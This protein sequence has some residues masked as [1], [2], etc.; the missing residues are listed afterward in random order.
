MVI[1]HNIASMMANRQ[2]GIST[3]NRAKSSEKLSSGYRINRSAD[4]AA[5]LA[6]SEKMRSQIRGLKR[7][8]EN[9]QD[10]I[11][12]IQTAD[13]SLGEDH[14]VVQRIRELCVQAGNVAVN[15][16]D[17]QEKIQL[18]IDQLIRQ[19]DSVADQTEFN[20]KKLLDGSYGAD[21]QIAPQPLYYTIDGADISPTEIENMDGLRLVYMEFDNDFETTQTQTGTATIS[22]YDGLK[23]DLKTEIVPQAVKALVTTLPNAFGYLSSSSIGIGLKLYSD[24]SSSTMASVSIG[25]WSS[26]SNFVRDNFTYK[27]SVNMGYLS[28]DSDGNLVTDP[29]DLKGRSALETT[30]VH[31]MMHALMDEALTNGMIGGTSG[32]KDA[33]NAFPDWFVEGTAQAVSGAASPYNDWIRNGLGLNDTSSEDDIRSS[34]TTGS[35]KLTN[36]SSSSSKYATGYLASM[37][38]GYLAASGSGVSNSTIA[39]GLDSL[40]AGI[41]NGKSLNELIAEY[42]PYTDITDF[43]SKFG[44]DDDSVAF[45]QSLLGAIGDGGGSL[46]AGYSAKD[47][48]MDSTYST[49]LFE[50]DTTADTIL[51]F[52]PADVVKFTD[53]GLGS[54]GSLSGGGTTQGDPI[55]VDPPGDN[56]GADGSGEWLQLGANEGEGIYLSIADMHA[57]AM[58]IHNITVRGDIGPSVGIEKCDAALEYIS[59]ERSK[60]GAFQNRL[61]YTV[62]VNDIAAEN[63]QFSESRLR[64]TDMAEEM[65]RY[66]KETILQQAGQS[67]LAQANQSNQLVIQLLQG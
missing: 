28:L 47:I 11:S 30:I 64:D 65:T 41:K 14:A 54:G 37:Y 52:Y 17:D 10:G 49:H 21:M 34:L 25:Y 22:G 55:G 15:T 3:N 18:E 53:G 48:L 61:E 43:E 63:L 59:A 19:I 24:P 51:N 58:G 29:S 38:L 46:V 40:L 39:S 36:G 35:N 32:T 62:K 31:E 13:G 23:D 20:T 27:L 67:V 33:S 12:L 1:A 5:G 57:R 9:A 16:L 56:T 26:G 66:S 6:I 42:G 60:L 2:L 45:I 8:S 44:V 4:D 7:A 50:L